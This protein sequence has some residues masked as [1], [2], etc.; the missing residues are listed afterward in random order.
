[1]GS[2]E[3]S[4]LD[5]DQLK[6]YQ[7]RSF[8]P[9][10]ADLT[11]LQTVKDLYAKLIASEVT[12]DE[13]FA[14]W[15]YDRSELE[16]TVDQAGS[17]LY[18]RM[19]CQ[20]DDEARAKAFTEFLEK[21]SP[22]IKPLD[23][24]LNQRFV[25]LNKSY[26]ID[27]ERYAEYSRAIQADIDLFEQ[28][29]V[30]LQ[31]QVDLLS[32]EYQKI[33]GS[34]MVEFD[35]EERTMPQMGKYLLE[36]DRDLRERAWKASANRRMQD[37]DKLDEIFDKM[38]NLRHQIALNA[39]CDNFM[40]YKFRQLHRFDYTPADCKQYHDTVEKLVVPVWKKV[41]ER[42]KARMK[43][44]QLKPWDTSVDPLGLPPLKPFDKVDELIVKCQKMFQRVDPDL[45]NQFQ[46]MADAGL[47]DLAS[48]K[49]KAPGGYQSSLDESRKPFIFMNAVGTDSDVNTL[50]HEGGHAFHT[51]A[52]R[53]DHLKDYRHGPMEFNEVASMAMELLAR[54]YIDEFY[55][56]DEKKR[57]IQEHLEDIIFI[58]PWVATIDCFQHWIYENPQH[59]AAER[60]AKWVEIYRRFSSGSVDWSEF[61]EIEEYLWHRQLH[62]FEVPFYYIEYGIAQLGALQVWQNAKRDW[63][64]AIRD[65]R[66]GLALGGSKPLP[67]IYQTAGIKFDFSAEIIGPLM[68]AIQTSIDLS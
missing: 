66:K 26:S 2:A 24:Q 33:C 25:E 13:Q 67:E 34:M 42:R 43:L 51:M 22:A 3:V 58:L 48:R 29:N 49:G 14:Q 11:D 10:D 37:K 28:R 40:E 32:Q 4:A 65:Y 64:G 44:D 35:G 53:A 39:G 1:M 20:T 21:I 68:D 8:V 46:E 19:T 63:S 41:C 18:I 59:T 38:L 17:I 56:E 47:L 62:I 36:Q 50:L 9:A 30:D 15:I 7:P 23:D 6:P 5:F 61:A 55:S 60:R 27:Q 31:T 45:G 57:S 54:E 52:C 16:A 12:S